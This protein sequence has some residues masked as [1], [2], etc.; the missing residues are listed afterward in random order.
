MREIRSYGSAGV[1]AGNRRHYPA[2]TKNDD[3]TGEEIQLRETTEGEE[4]EQNADGLKRGRAEL[5]NRRLHRLR[6]AFWKGS[7]TS[8]TSAGM[9]PLIH[10]NAKLTGREQ[11]PVTS[12]LQ[13]N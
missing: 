6:G 2:E 8:A 3:L 13:R 5:L 9:D 1:S 10:A 4:N 7:E 12:I 11:P